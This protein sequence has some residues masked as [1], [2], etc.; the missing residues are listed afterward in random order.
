M[1]F[2]ALLTSRR[3]SACAWFLLVALCVTTFV[4]AGCANDVERH[5]ADFKD[6][7]KLEEQLKN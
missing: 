5:A 1:S 2:E 3:A 7:T 4:L 6:P